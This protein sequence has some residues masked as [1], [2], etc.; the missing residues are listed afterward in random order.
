MAEST[1]M[2]AILEIKYQFCRLKISVI[3][4]PRSGLNA[5]ATDQH[6]RMKVFSR[7]VYGYYNPY[8]L[9]AILRSLRTSDTC[10]IWN[11]IA[12]AECPNLPTKEK[13]HEMVSLLP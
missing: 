13:D 6:D 7:S 3:E 11:A 10:S 2:S 12:P 4:D 9:V 8:R 5:L 1:K